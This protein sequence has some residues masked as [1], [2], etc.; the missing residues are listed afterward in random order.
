MFFA[1]ALGIVATRDANFFRINESPIFISPIA[2]EKKQMRYGSAHGGGARDYGL[3][4]SPPHSYVH[5][6]V[7]FSWVSN[8]SRI[9]RKANQVLSRA[10]N[11]TRII[12]IG[13]HFF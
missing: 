12:V 2:G 13:L 8:G 6:C 5:S 9:D 7:Y 1:F 10:F 4:A 11:V 3:P